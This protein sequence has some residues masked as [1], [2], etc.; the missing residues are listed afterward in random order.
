MVGV[1]FLVEGKDIHE[2]KTKLLIELFNTFPVHTSFITN[3]LEAR[4]MPYWSAKISD[5]VAILSD[6]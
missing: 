2:W 6:S 3:H 4:D 1:V 5:F